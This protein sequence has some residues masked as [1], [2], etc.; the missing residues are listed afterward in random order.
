MHAFAYVAYTIRAS[1]HSMIM[2]VQAM[3]CLSCSCHM[4]QHAYRLFEHLA[5]GH[6][7]GN[8]L[9]VELG[10]A[11]ASDHLQHARPVVLPAHD[12]FQLHVHPSRIVTA[13]NIEHYT[14]PCKGMRSITGPCIKHAT[15]LYSSVQHHKPPWDVVTCS[16]QHHSNLE[17]AA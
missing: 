15:A 14:L 7:D 6:D 16:V 11:G 12:P 3:I 5:L 8:A 4:T 13:V 2:A 9:G 1:W 17:V 10:P